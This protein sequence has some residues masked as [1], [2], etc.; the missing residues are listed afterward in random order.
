[1]FA[2]HAVFYGKVSALA[3]RPHADCQCVRVVFQSTIGAKVTLDVDNKAAL[4]ALGWAALQ[5]A[6]RLEDV[7]ADTSTAVPATNGVGS[8]G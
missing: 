4:E 8:H 5:A 7:P 2:L 1:M 3:E 6:E